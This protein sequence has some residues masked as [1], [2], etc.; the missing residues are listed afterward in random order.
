MNRSQATT[1]AAAAAG[2]RNDQAD[3]VVICHGVAAAAADE[4]LSNLF[5]YAPTDE[6][7]LSALKS[8]KIVGNLS[9]IPTP[10][11]PRLDLV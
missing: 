2:D 1:A 6:E 9:V 10:S 8:I 5:T 4:D 3:G 7:I 11:L